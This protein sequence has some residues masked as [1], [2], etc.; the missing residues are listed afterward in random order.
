MLEWFRWITGYGIEAPS[1]FSRV[2][3][4]GGKEAANSVLAAADSDND[5]AAFDHAGRHRDGVGHSL[6][7]DSRLPENPAAGRVQSPEP[8]V[9]GGCNDFAF[10]HRN[11]AVYHTAADSRLPDLLIHFR[12]GSPDFLAGFQ[13]DGVDDAPGSDAVQDAI[14]DD[15]RAFLMSLR[16][17]RRERNVVG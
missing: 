15:R 16:I 10:I 13:I 7:R 11:T 12:I 1:H 8:A 14:E 17:P 4:V 9:H 5:L 6:G 2:H 3:I